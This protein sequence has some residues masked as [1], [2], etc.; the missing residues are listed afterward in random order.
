MGQG[1]R[2]CGQHRWRRSRVD[3]KC[4]GGGHARIR[5]REETACTEQRSGCKGCPGKTQPNRPL[6]LIVRGWLLSGQPSYSE[7]E[8]SQASPACEGIYIRGKG[9]RG[10][11][12]KGLMAGSTRVHTRSL[13]PHDNRCT[14]TH[15]HTHLLS[16][17]GARGAPE[18]MTSRTGLGR[19]GQ[20]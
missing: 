16:R 9:K 15:A 1:R 10:L 6:L 17:K 2:G 13:T 5:I 14:Q 12:W 20:R 3:G 11:N 18:A 19:G 4:R 7:D 8:E